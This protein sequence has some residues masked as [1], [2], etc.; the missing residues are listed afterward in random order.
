MTDV[1]NRFTE[2]QTKLEFNVPPTFFDHRGRATAPQGASG[3]RI[4]R[5]WQAGLFRGRGRAHHGPG[6]ELLDHFWV[7][8]FGMNFRHI[9]VSDLI[10][11]NHEGQVVEGKRPVN[12]AAFVIHRGRA[13]RAADVIAAAHAHSGLRQSVLFTRTKTRPDHPRRLH[14]LRGSRSRH[15][16]WRAHRA[17]RGEWPNSGQGPGR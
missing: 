13:R 10:L 8:P 14:F 5:L 17:R 7:N 6:P 9:R 4:A 2:N 1:V 3:W 15:R 11:V 12:R 16:W